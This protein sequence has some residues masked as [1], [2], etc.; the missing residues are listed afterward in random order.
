MDFDKTTDRFSLR[1]KAIL[2]KLIMK[3]PANVTLRNIDKFSNF[4]NLNKFNKSHLP[5]LVHSLFCPPGHLTAIYSNVSC[6]VMRHIISNSENL[7]TWTATIPPVH[8]PI[9]KKLAKMFFLN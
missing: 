8:F 7:E 9:L 5:V 3:Q 2:L 1:A 6:L 4:L